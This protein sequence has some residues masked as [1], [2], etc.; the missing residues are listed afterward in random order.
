MRPKKA[1]GNH[2]SGEVGIG[3]YSKMFV[4]SHAAF[5]CSWISMY[6]CVYIYIIYI[7]IYIFFF[8]SFN[9]LPAAHKLTNH[10]FHT[11]MY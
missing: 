3:C 1:F 8:F 11:E 2:D 6:I 7:Y 5:G 4:G 9:V 10:A